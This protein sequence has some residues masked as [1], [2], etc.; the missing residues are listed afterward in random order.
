VLLLDEPCEGIQPSIVEDIEKV[1]LRINREHGI[2]IVIVE[3][4]VDFARRA[5]DWFV[6]V[7]KGRIAASGKPQELTDELVHRHLAV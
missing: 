5:A 3:Q 4:N 1:I 7:E 2:A 6:I